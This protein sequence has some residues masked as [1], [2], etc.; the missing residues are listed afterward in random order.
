V[1]IDC[2][3]EAS[4]SKGIYS[5][6]QSI[7]TARMAVIIITAAKTTEIKKENSF[8]GCVS[9]VFIPSGISGLRYFRIKPSA[10]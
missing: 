4:T 7:D 10:Y 2:E 5:A 1:A 9:V 6:S 3:S 8:S